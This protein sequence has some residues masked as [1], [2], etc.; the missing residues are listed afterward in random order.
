MRPP[1]KL[2]RLARRIGLVLTLLGYVATAVGCPIPVAPAQKGGAPFPCQDHACGCQSAEE[3]WSHCYC[4][5]P[6]QRWQWA[7]QHDVIPPD[8]AERPREA[9]AADCHDAG[10]EAEHSCCDHHRASESAGH[11][12][13]P[14]AAAGWQFAAA[15][16]HCKNTGEWLAGLVS[17][18]PGHFLAWQPALT[19]GVSAQGGESAACIL[20]SVPPVPPPRPTRSR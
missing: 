2:R 12:E 17:I 13:A 14:R 6:E 19:P 8:Y 10:C 20:S 4:F 7:R 9:I 15:R 5:T 11:S 3:C 18:V 16:H 1:A